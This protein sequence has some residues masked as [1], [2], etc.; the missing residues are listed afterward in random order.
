MNFTAQNTNKKP[1]DKRGFF[2]KSKVDWQLH[3][4][5]AVARELSFLLFGN[6]LF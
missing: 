1:R 4:L 2:S 5:P 6:I 3:F